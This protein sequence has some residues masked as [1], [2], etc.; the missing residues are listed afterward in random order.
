MWDQAVEIRTYFPCLK[1]VLTSPESKMKDDD[2]GHFQF[3][4]DGDAT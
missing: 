3:R 4:F 2:F 1:T